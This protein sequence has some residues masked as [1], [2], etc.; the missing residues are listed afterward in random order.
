MMRILPLAATLLLSAPLAAADASQPFRSVRYPPEI[1]DFPDRA[2]CEASLGAVAGQRRA[3]DAYAPP[4]QW[5]TIEHQGPTRDQQ[6]QLAYQLVR[7]NRVEAEGA[8][9]LMAH[10]WEY[11]CDGPQRSMDFELIE[12]WFGG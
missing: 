7:I 6:G 12:A 5:T 1:T 8:V 3:E 4:G 9:R 2:A 10:N 11:R